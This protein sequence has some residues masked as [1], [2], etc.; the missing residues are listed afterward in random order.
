M[1]KRE[2]HHQLLSIGMLIIYGYFFRPIQ[3]YSID[4]NKCLVA[5]V[6][7]EKRQKKSLLK[8]TV[9]RFYYFSRTRL[10]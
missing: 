2:K 7:I 1:N 5:L 10:I 6:G 4:S 9:S 3:W 8:W